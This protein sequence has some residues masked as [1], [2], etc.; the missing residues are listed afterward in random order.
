MYV[1]YFQAGQPPKGPP[2]S[3]YPARP[4]NWSILPEEGRTIG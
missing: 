2:T 4:K 1:P 3:H